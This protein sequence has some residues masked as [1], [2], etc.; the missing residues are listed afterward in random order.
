M[1]QKRAK[2]KLGIKLKEKGIPTYVHTI[3]SKE[4]LRIYKENFGITEVYTDFL[5]PF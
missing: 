2:E 5:G 3:N 4:E 1:P